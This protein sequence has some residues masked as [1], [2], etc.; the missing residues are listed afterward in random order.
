MCNYAVNLITF[1]SRNL[2]PLKELHKNVLKCFWSAS[3]GKNLVKDLISAYG[4]QIG[5]GLLNNTDY[6]SACDERIAKLEGVYYFQCET[7][8][9][10]EDNM[11]PIIWL[12]KNEYGN[13]VRISFSSEEPGNALFF[14]KDETGVF[15]PERYKV[16]WCMDDDGWDEEYFCTF[17]ELVEYLTET[18]PDADINY[19]DALSDIEKSIRTAYV[20]LAG[21]H[22]CNI[23][24]FKEYQNAY[25][26][27]ISNEEVA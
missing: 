21:N 9:A 18:F 17:N 15:Y 16:E 2:R 1:S 6:I 22:Y 24:R 11:L 23:Y 8:T 10:W 5:N 13:D 3:V 14:V 27:C 20:G 4:Y 26:D 25:D 19:Y 12:L 7:T